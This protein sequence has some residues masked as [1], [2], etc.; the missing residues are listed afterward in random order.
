[1]APVELA[2][3]RASAAP[4]APLVEAS[5]GTSA[6]TDATGVPE[7]R[8]VAEGRS[9]HGRG[10]IGLVENNRYTVTGSA[11]TPLLPVWAALLLLILT[12]VFA[13]WREG[14]R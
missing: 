11:E 13:W 1:M 4:L 6:F 5:A 14:R 7:L 3:L 8:R 10:W 2:D 12:Q 9:Y